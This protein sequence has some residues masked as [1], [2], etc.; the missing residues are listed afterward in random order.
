MTRAY[1]SGLAIGHAI[2][3]IAR[4]M[5]PNQTMITDFYH[6]IFAAIGG[7]FERR[8]I[9]SQSSRPDNACPD[10]HARLIKHNWR[11]CPDC[12]KKLSGG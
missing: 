12:H 7:E 9:T 8:N 4:L 3:E 5:H 10:Y 1:E 11:V 6:G 2:I